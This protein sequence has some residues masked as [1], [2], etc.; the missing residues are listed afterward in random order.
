M[1]DSTFGNTK[2]GNIIIILLNSTKPFLLLSRSSKK[3]INVNVFSINLQSKTF[4]VMQ[5]IWCGIIKR[6]ETSVI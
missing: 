2:E 3:H 4:K 1:K 6:K 5:N